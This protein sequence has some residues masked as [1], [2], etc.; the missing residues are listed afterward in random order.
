MSEFSD[1]YYL[2]NATTEDAVSLIKKIRRYGLVLPQMGQY[3]PFLVDGAWNPAQS[4]D[5]VVEE[6][7]GVL[8][9]YSYAQD[10]G[11]EIRIY[12][13]SQ[14]SCVIDIQRQGPSENALDVMV[15]ELERLGIARG[16]Q[17][18]EVRAIL[19]ETTQEGTV[20]L[21]SIRTRLGNAL[22]I[23]LLRWCGCADLLTQSPKELSRRFPEAI[24]VL[25][26][27]RGK[28]DNSLEPIPNE[29][30]PKPGL[31]VFMYL[32]V[33][34]GLVDEALLDRHVR[35]WQETNDWDDDKCVGFWVY[36]GYRRA[37]PRRMRYLADRIMNLQ[38]AFGS[39]H[40][41]AALRRTIRGILAAADSRFDWEPYLTMK[42]G[43]QRL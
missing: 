13:R 9:H 20:D 43:E 41:E 10:H 34:D 35:H 33:P 2:F 38:K 32:P 11:L 27:R 39:E 24:F 7:S 21:D 36:T 28:I 12:D 37:L 26:N 6:N 1:C 42:A 15:S 22:G 16:H 23:E 3:V 17:L 19:E 25:K 29:W 18:A 8:L 31:P 30:C 4:I 14:E 40:Y 5:V